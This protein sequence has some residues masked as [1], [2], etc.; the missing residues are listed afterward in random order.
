MHAPHFLIIRL[1][2]IGDIVMASGLIQSL[3]SKYPQCKISWLAE[4]VGASLL[5]Q[6]QRIHQVLVFDK[7]RLL[8]FIK[9]KNYRGALRLFSRFTKHLRS[10]Q[11]D[12]V[13]DAQGLLKSSILAFLSKSQ[14]SV[15]FVSK[16]KS[17]W[18]VQRKI[19]KNNSTQM[20]SE[21]RQLAAFFEC[22]PSDFVLKLQ[23]NT[24]TQHNASNS[25]AN[26]TAGKPY[27]CIAPFTT[28]AQK[29]WLEAYWQV[30]IK[31]FCTTYPFNIVILGAKGD[32]A[33][34]KA[35]LLDDK[36]HS[37]CGST[38]LLEASEI[39]RGGDFFVGVDT[40]LTHMAVMHNVAMA[41][42]FGS[43]CPYTETDNPR[44]HV[45]FDNL[46]CAPCKRS[47]TCHGAYTCMQNIVPSRIFEISQRYLT[48]QPLQV[49]KADGLE[50]A[51]SKQHTHD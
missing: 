29:H 5:S 19:T 30:L 11:Y 6:D 14:R 8:A 7:S 28:R 1:S 18:F 40:G 34:A 4:P 47:P 3:K 51:T 39:I 49:I 37:L 13:I 16:E 20:A 32:A 33:S 45:L 23:S 17:H 42:I 2:A 44:C 31:H 25:I 46:P 38:S 36:V 35:L 50:L 9:Q 12:Y 24:Q 41:V 26:I 48:S 10:T 27:I 21:Y 43:T 22:T 15:G